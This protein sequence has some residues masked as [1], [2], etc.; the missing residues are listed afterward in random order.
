[1]NKYIDIIKFDDT[2]SQGFSLTIFFSQCPHMC[3]GCQNPSTWRDNNTGKD[4]TKEVQDN[5]I[6]HIKENEQYYD[7]LVFS[8]GD[9]MYHVNI[10]N[11]LEF[12]KSFKTKFPNK[13]IWLYTGYTFE[14]INEDKQ[15]IELL[16]ICD[17]IKCGRYIQ[18]LK[19]IDN[20]QYSIR[21]ATSNQKIYKKGLD[22]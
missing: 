18:E 22:Y 14:Q 17:Y 19:T 13:D 21:I 20:I 15:K 9:P 16:N 10:I 12:A 5:I 6:K 2:N 8:G 11:T 1:M 7:A 4:F 3:E